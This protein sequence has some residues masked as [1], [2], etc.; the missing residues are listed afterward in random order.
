M[1]TPVIE[2]L[3][4]DYVFLFNE[5]HLK[6]TYSKLKDRWDGIYA[7]IIV[8]STLAGASG[9]VFGPVWLNLVGLDS[10]QKVITATARRSMLSI[11]WADII[12]ST[13]EYVARKYREG[14][15][16]TSLLATPHQDQSYLI[17]NLLLKDQTNIIC[18]AGG[19]GKSW[20]C[21]SMAAS[22]ATGIPLGASLTV[23]EPQ[24][25]LYLDWETSADEQAGRYNWLCKGMELLDP[26]DIY[27]RSMHRP[28]SEDAARVKSFIQKNNVGLVIV[29]S[30]A[31]ACGTDPESSS[32]AVPFMNTLKGLPCT[33]LLI[34]HVSKASMNLDPQD[35]SPFGSIFFMNLGRSVYGLSREKTSE[36]SLMSLKLKHLKTNHGM[37][38]DD[39]LVNI[40]FDTDNRLATPESVMVIGGSCDD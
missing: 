28:L 27:Y 19:V 4:D 12:M 9:R 17:D 30:A 15:P 24:P 16:F 22:V 32:S 2:L 11:D 13:S 35:A 14:E 34:T 6:L 38:R 23:P 37:L 3:G 36:R 31:P 8:E 5:E 20:L 29:D 26:P 40:R 39:M 25:V 21:L 7:E 1:T 33:R 18:S 10:I